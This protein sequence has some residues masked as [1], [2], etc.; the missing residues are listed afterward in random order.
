YKTHRI[1]LLSEDKEKIPNFVGGI[2]PRRDK[3]DHE[4][5]CRTMLTLF[6]PWTNPMSLKL[7]A[8]SWED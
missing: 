3:G 4:E 8:Q 6:K 1:R 7:P 2:L 5:Y